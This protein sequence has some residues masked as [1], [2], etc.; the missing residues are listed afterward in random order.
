MRMVDGNHDEAA[1]HLS[2]GRSTCGV[3]HTDTVRA[4]GWDGGGRAPPARW[5]PKLALA[6]LAQSAIDT[7]SSGRKTGAVA[8]LLQRTRGVGWQTQDNLQYTR[9]I[10]TAATTVPP[11][12]S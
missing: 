12:P 2:W 1:S 8:V 3:N 5:C 9:P 4:G 11:T 10:P 7:N 6:V